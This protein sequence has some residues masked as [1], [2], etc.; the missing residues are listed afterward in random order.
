MKLLYETH[1]L[2]LA[3]HRYLQALFSDAPMQ[4]SPAPCPLQ[5]L[6]CDLAV[7]WSTVV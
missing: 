7:A 5:A 3:I 1:C 4:K 2:C 6:F